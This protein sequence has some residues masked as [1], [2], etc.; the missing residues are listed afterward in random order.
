MKRNVFLVVF[1]LSLY[2]SAVA[3]NV[4]SYQVWSSWT[5]IEKASFI[6][7]VLSQSP[8]ICDL[9]AK[10]HVRTTP[11]ETYAPLFYACLT[12]IHE[13]SMDSPAVIK[14]MDRIYKIQEMQ[15]KHLGIVYRAAVQNLIEMKRT[16]K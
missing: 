2:S 9:V 10:Y 16:E 6:G 12:Q 8:K 1:T 3:Q 4:G 14:E 15:N 5:M 7:G 11:G 13:G